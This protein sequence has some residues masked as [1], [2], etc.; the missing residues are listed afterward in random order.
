MTK[1]I[2]Q[3]VIFTSVVLCA[4]FLGSNF[5][6]AQTAE[7]EIRF[8][9]SPTC[10]HCAE[11]KKFLDKLEKKYAGIEIK[12]YEFSQN[13]KLV[14][15]FY[16]N[17]NVPVKEQGLVPATFT[18]DRYFIGFNEQIGKE[19]EGC[20]Q[21]CLGNG[22]SL[23]QKIKI[24]I[25]GQINIEKI[26]FPL[27]A[28]IFGFF[29][30]FNVCSLGSL[31]LILGLAITLK[32]KRKILILGGGYIFVT[33]LVYWILIFIWYRLFTTI[34][35]YIKSMEVLIGLLS[36]A[37][38]W[39]L[40]RE[41]LNSRKSGAVCKLGGISE[42]MSKRI[43]DAFEKNAGILMMIGAVLFFAAAVT[44]IEFP[45]SAIFPVLFTNTLAQN[46]VPFYTSLLYMAIYTL[47]YMLDEL[48]VLFIAVFTMKIWIASPKFAVW[49]NLTA[50]IILFLFGL[51][52]LFGFFII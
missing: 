19:I 47:F 32:S 43:N 48:I 49:L 2:I 16:Q 39:Y 27:L 14:K 28:V 40:F 44:V 23:D 18:R 5:V 36:F 52:Y 34:S 22:A 17:Y 8:F 20:I 9:Y 46:N 42:K 35:P 30:G 3:A 50:S 1:K 13:I 7:A 15:E 37:G 29:D 11:E 33:I 6:F 12:R 41:F 38:A 26:S 10:P 21:Q 24:P 25:F 31:I 45:C 51:F 4:L